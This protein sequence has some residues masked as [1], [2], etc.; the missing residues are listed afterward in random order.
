M[1]IAVAGGRA[2]VTGSRR[3]MVAAGPIP[4][5]TPMRVPTK[6]PTRHRITLIGVRAMPNPFNIFW[7]IS[8][9]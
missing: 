8:I 4:G 6:H 1:M 3:A 7:K 2:V 5:R 9:C